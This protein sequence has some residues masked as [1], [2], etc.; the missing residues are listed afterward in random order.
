MKPCAPIV[1]ATSSML[2]ADRSGPTVLDADTVPPRCAGVVDDGAH[3]CT[4][5]Y[6]V[7]LDRVVRHADARRLNNRAPTSL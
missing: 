1:V 7:V 3:R 4:P 2:M 5:P 6:G